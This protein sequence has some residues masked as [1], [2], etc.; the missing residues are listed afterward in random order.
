MKVTN[1]ATASIAEVLFNE[2]SV[3]GI[4]LAKVDKNEFATWQY[5]YFDTTTDPI[6]EQLFIETDKENFYY[7]HYYNDLTI[8]VN[9][10]NKR[11]AKLKGAKNEN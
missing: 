3:I 2:K 7:G 11:V 9:D 1:I 5:S 4:I 8:A 10:Y 6:T